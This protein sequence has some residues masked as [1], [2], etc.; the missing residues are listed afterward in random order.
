MPNVKLFFNHKLVGADF[1][2][3]KAWLEVKT[4]SSTSELEIT[5]DLMIG[6]DGA[7][8]ATRYHLMKYTRMDYKQEYIDTLWCEFRIEQK[9]ENW[10]GMED[11][12]KSEEETFKA[13]FKMS[14]NHL[15]IWPGK[16]HMFI[17]IPSQDGSFTCTLFMPSV[18]YTSLSH[19]PSNLV[20]FFD[21]NFPGVSTLISPTSLQHS[22]AANPHL[23]LISITCT[24]YHY[25]STAVILGDAAHAM[26]PFYGQGMNAGL[27]SV[28]TL[29]SLLDSHLPSHIPAPPTPTAMAEARANAL[30]EYSRV[31]APDAAAIEKL[32]LDNYLEMRSSVT[33]PLYKLRKN[34]EEFLSINFPGLGVVTKYSLVSFGNNRYSEVVK[35]SD[36]QGHIIRWAMMGLG[37]MPL[38]GVTIWALW[39]WV[40]FTGTTRWTIKKQAGLG[41]GQRG[42]L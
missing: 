18:A 40:N 4:P 30:A 29:F 36:R 31:R 33:S 21:T 8:S 26:V 11:G 7:H 34:V 5:F 3:K 9:L 41:W 23:P 22:F 14:P 20:P 6:A 13:K 17:A 32:A 28:Y 12:G 10:G 38:A 25:T 24:P 19:N 15:H 35:S 27:E 2:S 16:D 39:R 42:W 37:L 1:K